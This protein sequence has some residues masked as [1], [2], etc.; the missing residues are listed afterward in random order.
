MRLDLVD[1]DHRLGELEIGIMVEELANDIDNHR[2]HR[3]IAFAQALHRRAPS[4]GLD[5]HAILG[6]VDQPVFVVERKDDPQRPRDCIEL[7]IA[8]VR[9]PDSRVFKCPVWMAPALQATI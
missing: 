5:A 3:L 8:Q 4:V 2:K 9:K 1:Q 6:I 7:L